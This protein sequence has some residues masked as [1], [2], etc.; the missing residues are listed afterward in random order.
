[1]LRPGGCGGAFAV[2]DLHDLTED[3][4]HDAVVLLAVIEL[5]GYQRTEP[6]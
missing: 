1:M 2:M 3:A 6:R 4:D 5:L